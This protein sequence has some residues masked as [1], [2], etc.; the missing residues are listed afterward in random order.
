M[1]KEKTSDK[2]AARL[3]WGWIAVAWVIL[4]FAVF[5]SRDFLAMY[6]GYAKMMEGMTPGA[7]FF[8]DFM[9][10]LSAL[11]GIAIAAWRTSALDRQSITAAENAKTAAEQAKTATGQFKLAESR[12]LND[13]F[14]VAAGLVDKE[15]SGR[16][17]RPAIT[18]RINGIRIMAGLAM[19][20]PEEFAEQ[21]VTSLISYIKNNVQITAVPRGE[22]DARLLGEDV[23]AAFVALHQILSENNTPKM[24]GYILDFSY[25]NFSGLTLDATEVNLRH[26]KKWKYTNFEKASLRHANLENADMFCANFNDAQ[27]YCAKMEGA[28]LCLSKLNSALLNRTILMGADLDNAKMRRAGMRGADLRHAD[29]RHADLSGARFFGA[30]LDSANLAYAKLADANFIGANLQSA[31][32]R[33]A[34]MQNTCLLWTILNADLRGV[35]LSGAEF[36]ATYMPKAVIDDD[37]LSADVAMA[38]MN[39]IWHYGASWAKSISECPH[40]NDWRLRQ[41]KDGYA[42]A[43]VFRNFANA[44]GQRNVPEWIHG[45]GEESHNLRLQARKLLDKGELPIAQGGWWKWLR[46]IDTKTGAHPDDSDI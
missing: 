46:D 19:K 10:G 8:R 37:G 38:M 16:K 17:P 45:A 13:Q 22:D 15:T 39:S 9:V 2:P 4:A 33:H 5:A 31:Q 6:V 18:A 7:R 21:V 24:P 1:A 12:L 28:R 26:Y 36:G 20:K 27:L 35:D 23:K 41:C 30:N 11:T 42:L 40:N 43:G 25:Q 14:V 3:P 29:M 32:L 34:D 44:R